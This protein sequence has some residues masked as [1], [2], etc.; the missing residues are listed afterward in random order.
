[1]IKEAI[2]KVVRGESLQEREMQVVMQDILNGQV[3]PAQLGSLVTGMRLKGESE[4]EIV[5]AAK[6]MRAES[7]GIDSLKPGVNLDRGEINIEEE[8]VMNTCRLGEDVTNT[9]NVSTAAA[10]VVAAGGL[11]V[12]KHGYRADSTY[13][14]SGDV[15]EA[16]GLNLDISRSDAQRCVAETGIAFLYVPLFHMG[17]SHVSG[18]RREIGIRTIFN[19]ISPLINPAGSEYQSLG[20]YSPELTEKMA[21]VLHRLGLKRA[22][23]FC[24]ES[25]LDEISI[26][27]PTRISSLKEGKIETHDYFPEDYGLSLAEPADIRGGNARENARIIREVLEGGPGPKQDLVAVNA[28][29]AFVISGLDNSFREGID[30]AREVIDSG[31]AREKLENLVSFT[32]RCAPFVRKE[33]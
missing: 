22:F 15:L 30:R 29:A 19:L 27:G 31:R 20:V 12:I 21:G 6:G 26:C 5:G 4:E 17:L 28:A 8:T 32:R 33:L 1:M 3:T 7:I 24:G 11:E 25:T 18:P 10:L 23:V 13:C 9:F 2:V 16:L 14:G